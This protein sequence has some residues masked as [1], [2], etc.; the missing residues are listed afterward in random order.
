MPAGDMYQHYEV[1]TATIR[2]LQEVT[3]RAIDAA[4]A[5][6]HKHS[7]HHRTQQHQQVCSAAVGPASPIVQPRSK[8]TAGA[9][10][11]EA[12]LTAATCGLTDWQGLQQTLKAATWKGQSSRVAGHLGF[13]R[14]QEALSQREVSGLCNFSPIV[15][16]VVFSLPQS[17]KALV[18]F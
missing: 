4:T 5:P 14:L 10:D 3:D 16:S 18:A 9:A 11:V 2:L 17:C 12:G 6:S 13:S 15:S 7:H 8:R 1:S